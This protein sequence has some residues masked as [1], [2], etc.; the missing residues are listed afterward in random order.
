MIA[1]VSGSLVSHYYAEHLLGTAF[2]GRL[3]ERSRDHARR[4]IR[5]WW[6]GD[7]SGLG[8]ASSLR[9]VFDLGAA[10]LV[11]VLG[12]SA[13]QPRDALMT[14]SCGVSMPRRAGHDTGPGEAGR[15]RC[16]LADAVSAIGHRSPARRAVG[17]GPR[18]ALGRRCA[19]ERPPRMPLGAV[20]QRQGA[21]PVRWPP[22]VRPG[23]PRVRHRGARRSPGRDG[24]LLGRTESGRTTRAHARHCRRL[25][26]AWRGGVGVAAERRPRRAP[27]LSA[28]HAGLRRPPGGSPDRQ[29]PHRLDARPGLHARLSRA[30]SAV[31]RVALARA[32]VASRIPPQL[33]HRGASKAGRDARGRARHLGGAPGGVAPGARRLPRRLARRGAVQ[34]PALRPGAS[35]VRRNRPP[36]RPARGRRPDGPHHACGTRQA[37]ARLLRRSRR[38]TTGRRLRKRAGLRT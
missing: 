14:R 1:G 15:A 10:P 35:A 28:G 3:G 20:L 25:G 7:G 31:R 19:R 24:P 18:P 6:R 2:A 27:A 21:P 32:D 5:A 26:P 8:P 22:H 38:R 30:L 33:H 36:R 9:A 16:W 12:F 4:R 17:R 23:L 37:R 11:G 29:R 34:R 13:R